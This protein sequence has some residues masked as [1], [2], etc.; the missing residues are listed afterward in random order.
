M[1][2]ASSLEGPMTDHDAIQGLTE[3]VQLYFDLLYEVDLSRFDRVFCPTA[4]LHGLRDGKLIMWPAETYR[5]V[6]A[7]RSSPRSVGAPREDQV[8]LIDLAS[9]TQA[10][11]KLR[12][13]VN[14]TVFVDYLTYHRVDGDW[15]VTAKAYHVEAPAPPA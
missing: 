13:R 9:P 12:V 15:R 8:L 3:A 2:G 6:L 7:G 1:I 5:E 14:Q 11:V 4:Q 10:L